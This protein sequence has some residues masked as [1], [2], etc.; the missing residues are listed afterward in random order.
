MNESV[1]TPEAKLGRMK[2]EWDAHREKKS[3]N[4]QYVIIKKLDIP[5]MNLVEFMVRL[6][7]AS[8]PAAVIVVIFWAMLTGLI[9]NIIK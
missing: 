9:V 3:Q 5:F 1:E 2:A 6:A 8:V 4:T 7:I